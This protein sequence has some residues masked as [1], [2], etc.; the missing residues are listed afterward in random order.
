LDNEFLPSQEEFE[1]NE[2]IYEDSSIIVASKPDSQLRHNVEFEGE[3]YKYDLPIEN[4]PLELKTALV[5]VDEEKEP[6]F[7]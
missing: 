1:I 6:T 2:A 7:T 5:V 4:K 3:I